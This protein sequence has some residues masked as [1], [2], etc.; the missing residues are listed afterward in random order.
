FVVAVGVA[1]DPVAT[2]RVL[3]PCQKILKQVQ[4]YSQTIIA[5]RTNVVNRRDFTR[6]CRQAEADGF[7]VQR[8]IL[9][10]CF[11][12]FAAN[13]N[14]RDA[15]KRNPDLRQGVVR[16]LGESGEANL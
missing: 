6:Q 11:S 14:G 1:L 7:I 3:T 4:R 10:S 5:S 8:L 9:Q 2:A 15:A 16:D 12:L 13:R